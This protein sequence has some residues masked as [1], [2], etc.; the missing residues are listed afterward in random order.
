LKPA[1]QLRPS[2]DP[3]FQRIKVNDVEYI[4]LNEL[5]K[6]GSSEVFHCY[7]H[8]MK[9]HRATKVV[10]LANGAS[11]TGF[12]NEVKMLKALQQCNRI[13]KM[14]DYEIKE[15]EK[16]LL[17]VLEVG[18]TDLSKILKESALNTTH[19]PLYMLLYYWMEMLYA[20]KQIHSHGIVHSDLKPANFL[21]VE[22]YLKL[23]DFGIASCIQSDMTSVVKAVPEGSF[24]YISPEALSNENSTNV[25]SPSYGKPKY[26]ISYK[27]D[28]WSLGCI[29]YQLVYRRTPFQHI[30]QIWVKLSTIVNA[31]HKIE[32]PEAPWVPQKII[33]TIRECLQRDVKLRPSVDDLILLY[34]NMFRT[35]S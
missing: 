35:L 6:G 12:I 18:G 31:E 25:N 2:L 5:G 14:F 20:V 17:V 11:A 1:V 7:N 27:S 34:E 22:G 28:V 4:I 19:M 29:L 24:N 13:I 33:D 30:S 21:K 15:E 23:I 9:T 10:S 16:I 32:Y 8:E 26:K 3:T